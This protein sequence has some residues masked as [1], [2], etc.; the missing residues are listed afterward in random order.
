MAQQ[1][2]ADLEAE[3]WAVWIAPDSIRPDEQWVE[4]IKRGL[5]ESGIFM[6]LLSPK[7][8]NSK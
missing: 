6:M 7:A 5:E 2:A 1:F 8:V 4:A 3:G